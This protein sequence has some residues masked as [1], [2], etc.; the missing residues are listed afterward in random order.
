MI[1]I[2][3]GHFFFSTFVFILFEVVLQHA[4]RNSSK[5]RARLTKAQ[6]II[7]FQS[8]NR[9][10]SAAQLAKCYGVTDKAIRDIWT[11]R[12]WCKE[13]R[14]LDTARP[15][16]VKKVGRPK[17]CR[18]KMPRKKRAA[19]IYCDSLLASDSATEAFI[20]S[21][22]DIIS[23]TPAFTEGFTLNVVPVQDE[24]N[25]TSAMAQIRNSVFP[26]DLD[27]C[28]TLG[29]SN[30]VTR[31]GF[32]REGAA[33]QVSSADH[34]TSIDALLHEWGHALWVYQGETDPFRH[35]WKPKRCEC[36]QTRLE[37][38]P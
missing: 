33:R 37:V 2:F 25:N 22:V 1:L 13:T 3:S 27:P 4:M 19:T 32:G 36:D 14:H 15:V 38:T 9:A 29:S 34:R 35:D 8:K 23:T 16:K 12:T 17:G 26:K 11:G 30:E 31:H 28:L 5:L 10:P 6:V 18:D 7:I 24:R 21:V 20:G